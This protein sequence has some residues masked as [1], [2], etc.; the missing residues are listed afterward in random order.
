MPRARARVTHRQYDVERQIALRVKKPLLRVRRD[1]LDGE[2]INR[3]VV[4]N[5]RPDGKIGE[6]RGKPRHRRNVVSDKRQFVSPRGAGEEVAELRVEAVRLRK[7]NARARAHDGLIIQ[8][9]RDAQTRREIVEVVSA[10]AIARAGW[11]VDAFGLAR[12]VKLRQPVSRHGLL[13]GVRIKRAARRFPTQADVER[14]IR[15]DLPF[16]L[17][18]QPVIWRDDLFALRAAIGSAA[19]ITE[20]KVGQPVAGVGAACGVVRSFRSVDAAESKVTAPE[21]LRLAE[22]LDAAILTAELQRVIA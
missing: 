20:Q 16:V 2:Q 3:R 6:T 4:R 5:R 18:E 10:T 1:P 19:D 22:Y 21:A 15:L 8:L 7:I 11:K 17:R 14:Q 13:I 9:P 12:A